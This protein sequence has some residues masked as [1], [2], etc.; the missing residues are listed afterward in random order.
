VSKR[1]IPTAAL[2]VALTFSTAPQAQAISMN[3]I[4]RGAVIAAQGL[5]ISERDE[6]ALGQQTTARIL[7]QMPRTKDAALEAYVGRIGRQVAAVSERPNLPYQFFV[8]ESKELNAF[9]AP[10]GFVFVTTGLLRFMGEEAQL[11][12]VLG[13]EVAH[14]AKKH[15]INAIR[16]ALVAQGVASA[17]LSDNQ[18]Q[19]MAIAANIAATL[20][21]K[22]FD[23]KAELEADR[24]GAMYSL[25]AGYDPQSLVRFL[26]ALGKASGEPPDWLMPVADHPRSNDRVA[27]L[28]QLLA[29]PAYRPTRTVV[30][31]RGA[32]QREVLSRLGRAPA[33]AS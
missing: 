28:R 2:A 6:I 19:L 31:N 5:F 8:L 20:I 14:V 26:D 30:T 27:Q 10:G 24:V 32:Y 13:H 29:T 17:V 25:R 4:L 9:A 23:R 16:K 7:Q 1:W 11:A 21:L 18:S 22:G 15:S 3:D 12:G 33:K